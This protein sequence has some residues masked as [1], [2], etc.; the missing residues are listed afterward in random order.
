M[1][2]FPNQISYLFDLKTNTQQPFP[3]LKVVAPFSF[4]W[5]FKSIVLFDKLI[6]FMTSKRPNIND[7]GEPVSEKPDLNARIMI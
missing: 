1:F 4:T 6:I 2:I 7:K 3:I 5:E